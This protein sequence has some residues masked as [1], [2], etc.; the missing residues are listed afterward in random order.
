MQYV[1]EYDIDI[2]GFY[3]IYIYIYYYIYI[4]I[5]IYIFNISINNIILLIEYI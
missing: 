5:Y 1:V 3:G 2:R 4:Y